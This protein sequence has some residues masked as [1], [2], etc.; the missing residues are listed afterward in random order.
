MSIVIDH[1]FTNNSIQGSGANQ[2]QNVRVTTTSNGILT[3]AFANG[4]SIDG[5]V[6][7]TNDRVLLKNQSTASENGIYIVQ[8][9][10]APLRSS[11]MLVG[12]FAGRMSMYVNAGTSNKNTG[13]ICTSNSGA[14]V[15][16]TNS[17][18]FTQFDV[19][20]TLSVVRGGTGVTSLSS[21][22]LVQGNGTSAVSATGILTSKVITD[23]G[24]QTLSNKTLNAPIVNTGI[25]NGSNTFTFPGTGGT[26]ATQSYV[27]IAAQGYDFKESVRVA[28]ATDLDS[29]TTI[30]G[31]ATYNNVGGTSTRGQITA[32]LVTT[33]ALTIDGITLSAVDNG[34]RVLLKNQTDASSNGIWTVTISGTSLI[35]DRAADFDEDNQVTS[36]AYCFIESGSINVNKG[37]LLTTE[38]PI[39]IGGASG[40]NLTFVQTT[41]AGQLSAGDGVTKIGDTIHIDAKANG[42]IVIEGGELA[43]DLQATSITGTLAVGDGGTGTTSLT[44][45]EIVQGNGTSAVTATGIQTSKV[46]TIDGTQTLTNKI[47]TNPVISTIHD[48]NS[49][50]TLVLGSTGAAVNYVMVENAATGGAPTVSVL[51][52]DAD[53][54][55]GFQS[56]G[57]G[58]YQFHATTSQA[59]NLR[60]YEDSD[61]G[62]H[63]VGVRAPSS[64]ISSVTFAL[65]PADSISGA[66]LRTDGSGNL[67]FVNPI[68]CGSRISYP[69]IPFKIIADSTAYKTVGY[70][71]WNQSRYSNYSNGTMLF[72]TVVV[73]RNLD[74]RLRDTT[75][76]ATVA[77]S[78]AMTISGFVLNS[79][80]TNP[81]A[82][83]RL[84]V[85]VRKASSGG[86]NPEIYAVALEWDT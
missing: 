25:T 75:N 81:T 2:K 30:L 39:V 22:E 38:N 33:D 71:I 63:Y 77:E 44:S 15:V 37:F 5:I 82:N 1:L 36:S 9:S 18:V 76:L 28:T 32:T 4:Q 40:T 85:Q 57:S 34:A 86:T 16:G 70:F 14:D 6:L 78:L 11:D 53:V 61:N 12:M 41:G 17:L 79:S 52:D 19:I 35:L 46:T 80:F 83:A 43:V 27:D 59:A 47:I 56:K 50:E 13:W 7:N 8:A 54:S 29:N 26:I 23:D 48:A 58:T 65:P 45:G 31:T 67:D 10:G 73:D 74:L 21:G 51:G 69:L 42:G 60:L 3:T 24:T 72:E 49:N 66:I 20:D 62:T 84:E 55:L 68:T 64:V